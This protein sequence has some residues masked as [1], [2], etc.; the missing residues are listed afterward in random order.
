MQRKRRSGSDNECWNA[1]SRLE[2]EN[3]TA[4]SEGDGEK[5]EVRCSSGKSGFPEKLHEDGLG[6]CEIVGSGSDAYRKD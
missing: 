6:S 4:G 3:P 1:W 2:K 5:Q